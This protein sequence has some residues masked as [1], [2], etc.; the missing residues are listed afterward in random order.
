MG[1]YA[2]A[3]RY[4]HALLGELPADQVGRACE[5]VCEAAELWRRSET[6]RRVMLNPFIPVEEKAA[7]MGHI[8]ERAEWLEVVRHF[9]GVLAK[10]ERIGLLPDVASALE[11][12]RRAHEG[13]EEAHIE[14]P[15]PLS[16]EETSAIAARLGKQLGVT[17]VPEVTVKPEL[18]GG[19][20]VR[21]GD[22]L[23]DATVAGS[24]ESLREHLMKGSAL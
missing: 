19:V 10:N 24:L 9:L 17:L 1:N 20:R 2:L 5:E 12:L 23:F 8:A 16:D 13:R 18:I 7:A 4:A 21:V 15:L 14:S 6:L 3:I 11:D 22:T